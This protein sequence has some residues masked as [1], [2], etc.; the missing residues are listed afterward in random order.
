MKNSGSVRSSRE[1][2]LSRLLSVSLSLRRLSP[3]T[4]SI[5]AR[6]LPQALA[7]ADSVFYLSSSLVPL[8]APELS[9]TSRSPSDVLISWL[10]IPAKYRRGELVA[11][12]LSFRLSTESSIQAL[13]LPGTTYEYLLRGLKPD[14]IYLARISAATKVGWG[15]A[16]LWTSHR[17]PKA[18]SVKGAPYFSTK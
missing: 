7:G 3:L 10:P 8:R 15:E 12:R 17:T 4:L 9:L 11:F 16:S 5:P 2:S 14:S 1:G 18:T 13:E 6:S